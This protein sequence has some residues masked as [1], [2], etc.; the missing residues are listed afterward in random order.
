M[1]SL[2]KKY[3]QKKQLGQ[4]YTP[5]TVVDKM[6]D[7]IGYVGASIAGKTVLDP[8]C[9]D[10]RFLIAVVERIIK[11]LPPAEWDSQFARLEGWDIDAL[12]IEQCCDNLNAL[13]EPYNRCFDWHIQ[14]Q[15][16]LY[17]YSNS[18]DRWDYIVGNPP[19]IRIQH[20]DLETRTYIQQHYQFCKS[21][22]TDIYI[23]FYELCEYLLAAE[24]CCALITPNTFLYTETAR[25]LRQYL[26]KN[27]LLAQLTNF[28]NIQ[29]FDQVTTYS[30]IAILRKEAQ[31]LF[32]YEYATD[33]NQFL[34]R[35]VLYDEIERQKTWQLSPT[36]VEQMEG[37]ILKSICRIHVGI[38][39]LC[40]KA[41]IFPMP[42]I[43]E[44][45]FTAET[46]EVETP[47]R[48][49]VRL[50]K[51]LL[52][53]IVKAST[54]KTSGQETS[55]CVLF[56]YVK[57]DGKH[58]II[59]ESVLQTDY[60]LA[61]AY[62]QSVRSMLDKR[63]NGRLNTVAWY[64]FGRS[65]GLDTSFGKKILFSPMNKKPN[66]VL[67]TAED[68]TFYSGY[69]IKYDGDYTWLLQQLNSDRLAEYI[70]NAGRDFRGGWK[71][72]NKRVLEEFRLPNEPSSTQVT[73][74]NQ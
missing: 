25:S 21:G 26:A 3:D 41:Y 31:P 19:Y 66:F 55:Q 22:S 13:L 45:A 34:R 5:R 14:L 24:G 56:P 42:I 69:C 59:P 8:A 53:P 2:T 23:A 61:Y 18:A 39:T 73:N 52:K 16:A 6:L 50:E 17:R 9:G 28:N 1:G 43:A 71:A 29:L 10:G 48:G 68:C 11:E 67:H 72:Y 37:T 47:L 32:I 7:D 65:Q 36:S 49:T 62:L 4:V 33:K 27:R 38:T 74:A 51:A 40:D 64:A 46:V 20:L 60:P 54:L 44:A 58:K 15:N 30:A 35:Q 12:A 57:L 63:D 70:K